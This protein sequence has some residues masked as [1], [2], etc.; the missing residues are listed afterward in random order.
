MIAI[1]ATEFSRTLHRASFAAMAALALAGCAKFTDPN[2]IDK[3]ASIVSGTQV[4]RGPALPGNTSSGFFDPSNSQG[5]AFDPNASDA[6]LFEPSVGQPFDVEALGTDLTSALGNDTALPE[7][8][9]IDFGTE[10]SLASAAGLPAGDDGSASFFASNIG[11]T[12]YFDTDSSDLNDTT[13]ET[14]RRQAAW[15]NIHQNVRITVEGHADERGTREYNLA[16]GDRRASA[17]RGFLIALGVDSGRIDKISYGKERPAASGSSPADWSRNRRTETV[18]SGDSAV[19][20]NTATYDAGTVNALP[21]PPA[22]PLSYDTGTVPLGTLTYD[23]A[24]LNAPVSDGSPIGT[25][26]YDTTAIVSD[27]F[28]PTTAPTFA[29]SAFDVPIGGAIP[30]APGSISTGNLPTRIEDV[31]V[32]DLLRDPSLIDRIGTTPAPATQ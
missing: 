14:L 19:F 17:T 29:P 10:Q 18:V 20:A 22:A 31:S 5:S 23:A 7:L 25:I 26:T 4:T 11:P 2:P 16:L 28:A 8:Q 1:K 24:P 12:V 3:T 9:S 30:A 21:S 27:P 6:A 32:D 15:L 13:R